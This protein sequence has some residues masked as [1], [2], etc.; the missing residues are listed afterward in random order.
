MY[1]EFGFQRLLSTGKT[2]VQ[3]SFAGPPLPSLTIP[4]I[5]VALFVSSTSTPEMRSFGFSS[6]PSSVTSML[7]TRRLRTDQPVGRLMTLMAC[8]PIEGGV[9]SNVRSSATLTGG[10]LIYTGTGGSTGYVLTENVV[11]GIDAACAGS[12]T[13]RPEIVDGG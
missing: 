12:L 1:R 11:T 13:M 4:E 7:L 2:S 5:V 9:S 6:M 8:R 10:A 3:H